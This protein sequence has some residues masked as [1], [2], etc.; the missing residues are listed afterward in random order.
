[1]NKTQRIFTSLLLSFCFIFHTTLNAYALEI[2][3][4]EQVKILSI[5]TAEEFLAF[6][7]QCR[8]DDYS[9]DLTVLL[10]N[11]IDLTDTGFDSIPIFLG[12]FEGNHHHITGLSITQDGSN[13]GLFR[14]L[15]ESATVRNLTV[16]GTITPDG[17]QTYV[18]GIVGTNYG[19]I[20]NCIFTGTISGIDYVGGIAG[21][22]AVTG[23]IDS[24]QVYG[25]IK[26]THF[27]GGIAGENKG[28][29]RDSHN[30]AKINTTADENNISLTEITLSQMLSSESVMTTT[31]IGGISG[32][33]SG[34]IKNCENHGSIGYQHMGYNIG[35]IAGRQSGYMTNCTNY[36]TVL[37]RKDV[38]GIVGQMEPALSLTYEA[39]TFQIL[40]R[41][42]NSLSVL[43]EN[44]A[45]NLE[46]NATF[47]DTNMD[48]LS[49]DIK[50]AQDALDRLHKDTI[51][52]DT[53][54][55]IAAKNDLADSLSNMLDTA[56][57]ILED[58]QETS[59]SLSSD[60]QNIATQCS[61]I[62]STIGSASQTLSASISDVSDK[63]T[64]ENTSGKVADSDNFGF[65]SADINAGGIA[66]SISFENAM[67]PESDIDIT[68]ESSLNF[69][70][71]ICA[72]IKDCEN[73]GNVEI[74][75]QNAGGIAGYASLG[76]IRNCINRGNI[77]S[78]QSDYIGGIAGQSNGYI[79]NCDTKCILSGTTYVGGIA[80][81]AKIV[82]DCRSMIQIENA[83]EKTGS[84]LGQSA[85]DSEIYNNYYLS[86]KED[87]GGID[88][89]SYTSKAKALSK[90]DFFA[91]GDLPQ[92][93]ENQV[94]HF[95]FEGGSSKNVTVPFG[96]RL[97]VSKIPAVPKREGYRG[98]WEDYDSL[99][100]SE[101]VFDATIPCVYTPLNTTIISN[102]LKENE[103][104]VLLATGEFLT[105][106]SIYVTPLNADFSL[107]AY[108]TLITQLE[109]FMPQSKIDVTMH[110]LLPSN[111]SAKHISIYVRT[112]EGNFEKR[113]FEE[114]G[115]YLLFALNPGETAFYV[116]NSTLYN[117]VIAGIS[118]LGFLLLSMTVIF[119][120]KKRK[121]RK[122]TEPLRS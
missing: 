99:I 40:N 51:F 29:I 10:E 84:I 66:G 86:V 88:G 91:L 81:L 58:N 57:N 107:T 71:E 93:Y 16:N 62:S 6:S 15:D 48:A 96:E 111:Y 79:R 61:K 97:D 39:D 20:E 106:N 12:T 30:A 34:V 110:Y 112:T 82:S 113:E 70:Y 95:V 8:F 68:G 9:R 41:Q 56:G 37:G 47:S 31:D 72:V 80:G 90:E 55:S 33:N 4:D 65:I 74:K 117:Y 52:P 118:I 26:G 46:N 105:E 116:T 102:N 14:Y 45:K 94:L 7:K 24:C 42:L 87:F 13:K 73:E 98:S 21:N 75:K 49:D 109:F 23:I 59:D 85:S 119:I 122:K 67:D 100:T 32:N 103:K 2:L 35:G 50:N 25:S 104:P 28:V 115:S 101:I 121:H 54:S 69:R 5:S 64:I 114:N 120:L 22:N 53:D 83:L 18:G 77:T 43:T 44:A 108:E 11:D 3:P 1:M 89:I 76:L 78:T 60:L 19:K 36:G 17:S 38:G 63:D 92:M 27:L